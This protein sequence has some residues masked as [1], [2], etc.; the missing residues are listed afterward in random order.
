MD[1]EKLV[2][3]VADRVREVLDEAERRAAEIVREAEVDARQ[4]RER[5]EAEGQE[6]VAEIRRALDDLQ[7]RLNGARPAAAA[8]GPRAPEPP[9]SEVPP[10]PVPVP[11]PAPPSIPEPYPEPTPEPEPPEVPEPAPPPDEGDPPQIASDG[12]AAPAAAAN[13]ADATAA[14]LV[15]MNMALEGSSREEIEGHLAAHYAL[16]DAGA[17]VDDV[18]ALAAR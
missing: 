8:T 13:S 7:G 6:R 16:A 11:E 10:G 1:A 18:L 5:A 4:I 17:I 3:D 12:V 14:R 2:H 9:A 15:A